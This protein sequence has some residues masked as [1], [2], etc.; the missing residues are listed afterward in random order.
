M[1]K[2]MEKSKI[3]KLP[4]HVA[5]IMDGNGR[6]AKA[7]SMPRNMG[8]K[9][10]AK[11]LIDIIIHANKIGI[12]YLTSFAFSTENWNRPKEE[13]DYLMKL[14]LE[15]FKENEKKINDNNIKVSFIGFDDKLTE[16]LL[17]KKKDIVAKTK[18]NKGLEFILAFNYGS[19]A[20]ILNAVNSIIK[21]GLEKVDK[22]EF[23]KHLFTKGKPAV[24]FLIR[25]S[26][27]RRISNFLLW[28]ISYAELYFTK[29]LWPDF[30]PRDFDKAL[31]DFQKRNRRYGK[32]DLG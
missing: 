25:T 26:N 10:G 2:M 32:V 7:K 13:V 9:V 21:E 30:M 5:I 15:F 18:D 6:W 16:E 31:K 24:D 4:V 20:E 19:Q 14:P 8:H 27:E 17:K 23:E 1:V 3:K 29:K 28:Q 11:R 22:D 12:K